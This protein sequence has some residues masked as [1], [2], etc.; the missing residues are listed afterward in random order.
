MMGSEMTKFLTPHLANSAPEVAAA[1]PYLFAVDA[2][3]FLTAIIAAV[4]MVRFHSRLTSEQRSALIAKNWPLTLRELERRLRRARLPLL[5][6]AAVVLLVW[7][8]LVSTGNADAQ[9]YE[10][11]FVVIYVGLI[12]PAAFGLLVLQGAFRFSAEQLERKQSQEWR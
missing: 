8:A 9:L 5:I 2:L 11:I 4:L 10:I 7:L 6:F 12:A 3:A 1:V